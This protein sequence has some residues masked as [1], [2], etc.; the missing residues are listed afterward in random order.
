MSIFWL[1]GPEPV[2][3]NSGFA[4]PLLKLFGSFLMR[5]TL[6]FEFNW[7]LLIYSSSHFHFVVHLFELVCVGLEPTAMLVLAWPLLLR[8]HWRR[9]SLDVR[10]WMYLFNL[11]IANVYYPNKTSRGSWWQA[12]IRG[13]WSVCLTYLRK[14]LELLALAE[15]KKLGRFLLNWPSQLFHDW[16]TRWPILSLDCV[17]ALKWN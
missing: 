16:I 9:I 14:I 3:G 5:Q 12:W 8:R 4:N 6:A 1:V 10:Q 13:T 15:Y 11:V 7:L 17:V 2:F